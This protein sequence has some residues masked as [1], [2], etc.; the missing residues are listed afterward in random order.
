MKPCWLFHRWVLTY[1]RKDGTFQT[2]GYRCKKCGKKK[3][4]MRNNY[5]FF[6]EA[7]KTWLGDEITKEHRQ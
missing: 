1:R 4:V 3:L 2:L 5:D 6:S 7:D